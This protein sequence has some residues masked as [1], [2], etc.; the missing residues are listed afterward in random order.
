VKETKQNPT[1]G[2]DFCLFWVLCVVTRPEESYRL[3][4]VVV[5]DLETSRMMRPW[6]ALGRSATGKKIHIFIRVFFLIRIYW[7]HVLAVAFH[8]YQTNSTWS[9]T[10]IGKIFVHLYLI[11]VQQDANYSVYYI[12]ARSSTCFGCWHPSSSYS[13]RLVTFNITNL[14]F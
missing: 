5:C 2:M 4:C 14:E 9:K 12:S 11:I 1:R 8:F 3:W 13:S 7:S 6:P 10:I